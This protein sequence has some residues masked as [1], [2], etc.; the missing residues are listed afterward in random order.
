MG[1]G[2]SVRSRVGHGSEIE[3][4]DGAGLGSSVRSAIELGDG[5]GL[6]SNV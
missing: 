6:G 4:G 2:S 3:L 1:L 5:A